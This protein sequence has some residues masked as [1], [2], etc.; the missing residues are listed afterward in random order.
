MHEL[1]ENTNEWHC[2]EEKVKPSVKWWAEPKSNKPIAVGYTP[3]EVG[4][5][6]EP[7]I[8]DVKND[9]ISGDISIIELENELEDIIEREE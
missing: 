2:A 5:T 6:Q 9:Y 4:N 7:T 1:I 3:S 8:E